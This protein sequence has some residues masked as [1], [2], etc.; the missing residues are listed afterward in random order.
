MTWTPG[1][2]SGVHVTAYGAVYV[3]VALVWLRLVDGVSLT[4][5]DLIG[6]SVMLAGMVVLMARP[7]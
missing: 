7:D 1:N 5:R 2:Q 6:I 4:M 3:S